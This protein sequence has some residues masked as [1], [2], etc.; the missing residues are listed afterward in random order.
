MELWVFLGL[1]A[2]V[3]LISPIILLIALLITRN[4]LKQFRA[5]GSPQPIAYQKPTPVPAMHIAAGN[6][7]STVVLEN[8]ILL[9]LELR[10][11]ARAE[12]LT[13]AQYATLTEQLD[14]L[15][16]RYLAGIQ[17]SPDSDDWRERRRDAWNHFA[18]LAAQ[19]PGPPPWQTATRQESEPE[20]QQP[21]ISIPPAKLTT[22]PIELPPPPSVPKPPVISQSAP[23]FVTKQPEPESLET[24]WSPAEPSAFERLLE[25]ISG[26]PKLAVPFLVQNI[27]WFIGGFCLIAGTVFLV[28]NTSGFLFALVVFA[29]LMGYSGFLLWAGYQLRS[30]RP[31]LSTASGVLLSISMLLVP[32]NVAV[33]AR[34]IASAE[35]A[36]LTVS[37]G[38]TGVALAGLYW[39]V[40]LAS[41]LMDRSLR[42][43]HPRLVVA[44]A[45]VQLAVPA[46]P[47]AP[48]WLWL[49]ALHGVLLALMGYGL[50][51]F[52]RHWVRNWFIDQ[53]RTAYY[54]GGLLVYTAAVSFIHLTWAYPGRLPDGYFGPFLMIL[55]GLLFQVDAAFKDWVNKYPA[56]SRF[57][58]GLYGLSALAIAVGIQGTVPGII[59]LGLGAGLYGWV[60]WRYLTWPPLYLML[61]CISGAY[62]LLVL[63]PLVYEL[64]FLA[65]LPGLIG[66]LGVIR[67]AQPR[68]RNLAQQCFG[69][70][71]LLLAGLAGWS[72]YWAEPGLPG[73]STALIASAGL[74]FLT[75]QT[76]IPLALSARTE[77]AVWYMVTLLATV[78]VLYS[79]STTLLSREW[80]WAFGCAGL[81]MLWTWRGLSG[82]RRF[83][84]RAPVFC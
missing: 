64:Y 10:R 39:A 62:G 19:P 44:M 16:S 66:L 43:L 68:S 72:L 35:G 80:Q 78:A 8:F 23:A 7:Y 54:A 83:P 74:Y 13:A 67:W 42:G 3:W 6:R 53:R 49:A 65:S 60:T 15:W 31:E 69:V 26:W 55:S 45:A 32:L 70:F 21:S 77:T 28:R 5:E 46:L 40:S 84:Q 73:M 48:H 1:V 50:F 34:L 36:L 57:T 20:A 12:T 56:L 22:H 24:D 41:T 58:F 52:T 27:G 76:L 75:R 4:K 61:A 11:Q 17:L 51:A 33:A 82:L 14:T 9:H 2:F 47:S 81:A 18:D 25:R 37:I 30:K 38:L 29:S 63:K 79:P 59:T 71:S